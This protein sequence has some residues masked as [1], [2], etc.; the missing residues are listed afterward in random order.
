VENLL[1]LVEQACGTANALLRDVLFLGQLEATRLQRHRTNLGTFLEKRVAVF[2]L[3]AQNK[4][5]HM[6]LQLPKGPIHADIH[7][8]KFGRIL[9]NLLTNALNFT[10]AGG[11]I[12]VALR[13]LKG[14]LLI[15]LEATT[16][17]DLLKL[18]QGT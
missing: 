13:Q 17:L 8:E 2:R 16:R 14:H 12:R 11:T 3:S 9:D 1:G 15:S 10:P 7:A 4:S 5:V 6:R 18:R